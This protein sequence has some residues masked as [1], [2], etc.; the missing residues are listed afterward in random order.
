MVH[1]ASFAL[2]KLLSAQRC[3]VVLGLLLLALALG[4]QGLLFPRAAPQNRAVDLSAR[5]RSSWSR[6][7]S[8]WGR[9]PLHPSPPGAGTRCWTDGFWSAPQSPEP[10]FG[11]GTQLT[12]LGQP[13]ASP[14]VTLFPPSPEELQANKATLACL[15]NDFYPGTV[16]VAWKEDDII[17]TEG[18]E[19][20]Q[21]SKQSNNKYMASSYL[22]LTPD[23]W[24]S[25]SRYTC[26]VTHEG[27]T[28]EKSV[29]H[30]E[31]S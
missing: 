3:G 30:V 5:A 12:V 6:L 21:P 9:F 23:K 15:M 26:H 27:R 29:S 10:V 25:G 4:T 31:C 16:M 1:T 8:L 13:K 11:S 28:I 22:M 18:V 2:E 17:I 20:T 19:T 14:L 24:K 7:W